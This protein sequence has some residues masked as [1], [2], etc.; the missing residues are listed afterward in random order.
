MS[1]VRQQGSVIYLNVS[2]H[3]YYYD[4]RSKPLGSGAM[5][6][7]YLGY[8]QA[9]HER[10]A[11]KRVID[12]YANIQSI[13]NK[14]KV[15]A[16]LMFRHHNLVEMIGCCEVAP[17][18]GPIFIISKYVSGQNIDNFVKFH[19]PKFGIERTKRICTMFY[20]V[21]D[22]LTY[23]H[24]SNIVHLDIKPS[25]IMVENGNNVRLMDLGIS[26]VDEKIN[27]NGKIE[28]MG[29]PKYAAPEQFDITPETKLTA[30]TDIYEAGVTLFELLSSFNPFIADS[31]KSSYH[32]HKYTYLPYVQGVPDGLIDVLRIATSPA[33]ANRFKT[34]AD[35]KTAIIKSLIPKKK[36]FNILK[37]SLIICAIL[38]VFAI[39]AFLL[40]YQR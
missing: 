13:R 25:N 11:I 27:T 33:A 35:F 38:A 39:L 16:S 5:G 28:L 32:K 8:S 6:V 20:P 4:E 14:A 3:W 15:E 24:Y 2:G 30:Q 23:I 19:F 26:H 9:T 10:V 7:V 22:A 1:A 18:K 17:D 21:L 12:K 34:A 31:L 37:L 36:R 40:L 29:T